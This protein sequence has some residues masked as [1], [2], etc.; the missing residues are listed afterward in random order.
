VTGPNGEEYCWWQCTVKGGRE[1]RDIDAITL[2]Q[3]VEALGAGEIMLNCIDRDGTNSVS[4]PGS[5][6][7]H[8]PSESRRENLRFKCKAVCMKTP[9]RF[10]DGC[11]WTC[12]H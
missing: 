3:G 5:L 9:G 12:M 11:C 2:A 8:V 1:G 7:L 10:D 4:V 6:S